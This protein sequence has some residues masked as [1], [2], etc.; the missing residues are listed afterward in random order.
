[1]P[2]HQLCLAEQEQLSYLVSD[3]DN[4]NTH[5]MINQ[6]NEF[7]IKKNKSYII[8]NSMAIISATQT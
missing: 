7:D 1:M 2:A 3:S 6:P 5:F 4:A 8:A